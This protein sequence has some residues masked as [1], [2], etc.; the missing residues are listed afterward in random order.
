M[1][2]HLQSKRPKNKHREDL[3]IARKH[4]GLCPEYTGDHN[5]REQ[6]QSKVPKQ[7][8]I[9]LRKTAA[10]ATAKAMA[11]ATTITTATAT[12]NTNSDQLVFSKED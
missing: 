7:L 4:P 2:R 5:T 8:E 12:T 6:Q 1:K 11:T 3:W 9:K 10:A